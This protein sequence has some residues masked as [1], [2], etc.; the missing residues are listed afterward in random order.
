MVSDQDSGGEPSFRQSSEEKRAQE[1]VMLNQ[2]N[3]EELK[4]QAL[5][6]TPSTPDQPAAG[7][8]AAQPAADAPSSGGSNTGMIIAVVVGIV[9][10]V[11]VIVVVLLASGS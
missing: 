6:A 2:E 7:Q 5:A 9:V 11:A 4:A 1:T 10:I 3:L 8:A